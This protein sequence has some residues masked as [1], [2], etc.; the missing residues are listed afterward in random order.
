M[1]DHR[2]VGGRNLARSAYLWGWC[3]F[4]RAR[5]IPAIAL[6]ATLTVGLLAVLAVGWLFA[7]L[8][9][10]PLG[11]DKIVL[12]DRAVAEWVTGYRV[13][14]LTT[15]MRVATTLGSAVML[16]PI[17]VLCGAVLWRV[18]RDWR[19]LVLLGAA[20]LGSVVLYLA[21]KSLVGRARPPGHL[22][23]I[24]ETGSAFPSGHTLQAVAVYGMLSWLLAQTTRRRGR[25]VAA[26]LGLGLLAALISLSRIYLGVHW[27]SDVLAAVA[28]GGLWLAVL[29]PAMAL[30]CRHLSRGRWRSRIVRWSR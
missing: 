17:M 23:A 26:Y 11:R 12:V 8:V 29:I 20:W 27:L 1:S 4:L 9:Q 10:T 28:L 19:P 6:V 16:V 24:A 15:V 5:W 14:W 7:E 3:L 21:V 25:Q 13:S 2:C 22:A 30:V 18:L